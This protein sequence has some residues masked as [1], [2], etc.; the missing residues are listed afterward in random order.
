MM[1]V[2]VVVVVVESNDAKKRK[3]KQAM[4]EKPAPS[5]VVGQRQVISTAA[6]THNNA[7]GPDAKKICIIGQPDF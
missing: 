6:W 1:L 5:R 4:Q 2:V 7:S 3:V